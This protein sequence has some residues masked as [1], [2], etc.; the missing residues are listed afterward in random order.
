MFAPAFY[1]PARASV[2]FDKID[3]NVTCTRTKE[4][5][6]R[7]VLGFKQADVLAWADELFAE[8]K[9]FEMQ[10][11]VADENVSSTTGTSIAHAWH[12]GSD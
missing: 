2:C 11:Q 7:D 9:Q 10:E 3:P 12:R 5:W 8:T 1:V 6:E 4:E